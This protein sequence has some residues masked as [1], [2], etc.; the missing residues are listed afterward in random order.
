MKKI[1]VGDVIKDVFHDKKKRPL[2][3][4]RMAEKLGISRAWL[5]SIVNDTMMEPPFAIQLAKLLNIDIFS[6]IKELKDY[7]GITFND[8]EEVYVSKSESLT[9]E[10]SILKSKLIAVYEENI[11]L[12]KENE[13]L[14]ELLSLRSDLESTDGQ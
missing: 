7:E 9:E 13:R 4:T 10:I 6:E 3:A 12:R 11:W 1:W 2:S 5:Y 14:R 8:P